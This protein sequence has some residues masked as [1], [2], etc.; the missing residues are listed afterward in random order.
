MT[1]LHWGILSDQDQALDAVWRSHR[2]YSGNLSPKAI[3]EYMGLLNIEC[4]HGSQYS[5]GHLSP[6]KSDVV[7]QKMSS[8]THE[9]KVIRFRVEWGFCAAV[10]V[11]VDG[12]DV[13]RL[14]QPSITELGSEKVGVEETR[15]EH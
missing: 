9:V 2:H 4:I 10:I 13:V 15:M 6:I 5:L 3:A 8:A 7:L 14:G 1:N 12:D 11:V